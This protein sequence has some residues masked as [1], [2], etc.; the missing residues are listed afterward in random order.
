MAEERQVSKPFEDSKKALVF[1]IVTFI[2]AI[3]HSNTL[4]MIFYF[5]INQSKTQTMLFRKERVRLLITPNRKYFF[6][7]INSRTKILS[8]KEDRTPIELL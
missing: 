4:K 8:V 3:I 1:A 7:P 5:T 2:T 6:D